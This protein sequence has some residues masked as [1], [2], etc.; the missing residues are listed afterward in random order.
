M[1]DIINYEKV[2]YSLAMIDFDNYLEVLT[3]L[4]AELEN[5]NYIVKIIIEKG[6]MEDAQDLVREHAFVNYAKVKRYLDNMQESILKYQ[7]YLEE[8]LKNDEIAN[9]TF[10]QKLDIII[11][12]HEEKSKFV[13][14]QI[15]KCFEYFKANNYQESSEDLL[16]V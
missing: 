4:D 15:K 5:P 13:E 12:L 9:K 10:N 3:A 6:K 8:Y 2:T 11:P 7:K 1:N 16:N 14:Q